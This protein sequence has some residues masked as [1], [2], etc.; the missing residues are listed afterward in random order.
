MFVCVSVYISLSLCIFLS[1]FLCLSLSLSRFLSLSLSLYIYIQKSISC[2]MSI[3]T[4]FWQWDLEI[5]L[6]AIPTVSIIALAM[7]SCTGEQVDKAWHKT[8]WTGRRHPRFDG[9]SRGEFWRIQLGLQVS[10]ATPFLYH[11]IQSKIA[12]SK[13]EWPP[14]LF[15]VSK[16]CHLCASLQKKKLKKKKKIKKI[17]DPNYG[18]LQICGTSFSIRNEL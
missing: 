7:H 2:N 14:F 10:T 9:F 13:S 12:P 5:P 8:Q 16:C 6:T 3:F 17:R 1:L 18:P 4:R 15:M 11:W